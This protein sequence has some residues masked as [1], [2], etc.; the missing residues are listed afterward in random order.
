MLISLDDAVV[1]KGR[2][3]DAEDFSNLILLSAPDLFPLLFTSDAGKVM[4][5]LFKQSRNLF[6]FEHTYF[7]EVAGKSVGMTLGYDGGQRRREELR[8]GLLVVK[9]LKWSLFA[10]IFHLIKALSKVGKIAENEYY[11]SNI[12]VYPKFRRL[13]L[14]AKLLLEIEREAR[15]AGS[16]KI[17]LDVETSNET[18]FS[19]YEKRGYITERETR[20]KINKKIFKFSRMCKIFRTR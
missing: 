10:K 17:V 1:R 18:A 5:N 7:I 8:T 4:E 9:Y 14:G 19:F 15:K 13:G 16:S 12:A 20:F 6:S 3:E 2:A 11:I